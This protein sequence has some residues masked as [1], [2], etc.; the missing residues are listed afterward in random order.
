MQRAASHK[1]EGDFVQD[2]KIYT[3]LILLYS[4]RFKPKCQGN[5]NTFSQNEHSGLYLYIG[6]DAHPMPVPLILMTPV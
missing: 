1:D 3:F 2:L 4:R 5:L 6:G